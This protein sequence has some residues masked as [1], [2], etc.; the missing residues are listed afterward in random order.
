MTRAYKAQSRFWPSPVPQGPAPGLLPSQAMSPAAPGGRSAQGAEGPPGPKFC[1]ALTAPEPESECITEPGPGGQRC[2]LLPADLGAEAGP[3]LRARPCLPRAGGLQSA[4]ESRAAPPP[5]PSLQDLH[6]PHPR[7]VPP[8]LQM[9]PELRPHADSGQASSGVRARARARRNFPRRAARP[10]P[11]A[12]RGWHQVPAPGVQVGSEMPPSPPRPR[13]LP[14]R[15]PA[16]PACSVPATPRAPRPGRAVLGAR[17]GRPRPPPPGADVARPRAA[18]FRSPPRADSASRRPAP[19]PPRPC[20]APASPLPCGPAL[21]RALPAVPSRPLLPAPHTP[22]PCPQLPSFSPSPEPVLLAPDRASPA[23]CLSPPFW[24]AEAKGG[25]GAAEN[26]GKVQFCLLT[27]GKYHAGKY[28]RA[29]GTSYSSGSRWAMGTA[30]G[31][32]SAPNRSAHSRLRPG[33]HGPRPR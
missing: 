10:P 8:L 27:T 19:R 20:P 33:S 29:S 16:P 6:P 26:T 25:R 1:H 3:P 5:P 21:L 13:F 24:P 15:P 32:P 7:A 30:L 9:D 2:L 22:R 11:W 17:S 28:D 18:A 4:P 31:G 14:P 23:P 12:A